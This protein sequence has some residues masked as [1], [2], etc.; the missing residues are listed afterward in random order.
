VI[1]GTE[2]SPMV[3]T[4]SRLLSLALMIA[5]SSGGVFVS[6][7]IGRAQG[8]HHVVHG[9]TRLPKVAPLSVRAP[10]LTGAARAGA[11][12]TAGTGIWKHH[13][14]H[15]DYQWM[16]CDG[17][18][19]NCRPIRGATANA[20]KIR[21]T[22]A[23]MTLRVRLIATNRVGSAASASSMT[24]RIAAGNAPKPGNGTPS[25]PGGGSGDAPKGGGGSGSG[26]SDP[27]PTTTTTTTPTST[28]P[29]PAPPVSANQWWAASS[30][31]NQ[32]IPAGARL[33][34]NS[35][36][37][38]NMLL[39]NG[40]VQSIY[41]NSDY[42][43]IN[44]YHAT[45]ATPTASIYVQ[46]TNK[47]ITI[48]YQA[49]WKGTPDTDAHLA[50]IDDSTGCE[51][52]FQGFDANNKSAVGIE[53]NNIQTGSGAHINDSGVGG[54]ALSLLGGLITPQDIASGS[55]NHALRIATPVNSPSYVLPGTVSDGTHPG[56]IPE[57]Q[58]L[59]LDPS[60]DLTPYNL[61]PFQ[62][63]VA[64][65]LQTYGAYDADSGASFTL[66]TESTFDGSTYSQ[67]PT[68]LPKTLINHLQFLTP[69]YSNIPLGPDATPRSAQLH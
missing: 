60:L 19:G 45:T 9:A 5:A 53:I 43:T 46:N 52:E 49:A 61:N 67:T 7:Q 47:H 44:L 35:P 26:G 50:V 13:P 55:I 23:G 62:K 8:E 59:R 15:F 14:S 3:K 4:V 42:W 58:L 40:N 38:T 11:T 16:R 66:Y 10:D 34:A 57:G 37:W 39:A 41:V 64:K 30:F 1:G 29:T 22:F 68:A 2:R 25:P 65:A 54:G 51:Y 17:R 33:D 20:F 6:T 27:A 32:P 24:Y 18:G 36:T 56:G 12:L 63:T 69:L 21:H 28:T 31:W 48:P